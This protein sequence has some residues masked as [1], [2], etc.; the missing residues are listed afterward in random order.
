MRLP[1]AGSEADARDISRRRYAGGEIGRE[2]YLRKLR[3]L[4]R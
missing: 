1:T 2:E 4:D 3:D